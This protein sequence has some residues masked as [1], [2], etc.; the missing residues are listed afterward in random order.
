MF[1]I[2]NEKR[3]QRTSS[4]CFVPGNASAARN[5]YESPDACRNRLAPRCA[6]PEDTFCERK[7]SSPSRLRQNL[8]PFA[9]DRNSAPLTA[10]ETPPNRTKEKHRPFERR[11]TPPCSGASG[12]PPPGSGASGASPPVVKK[13]SRRQP[14]DRRLA[15][16]DATEHV[17]NC[18]QQLLR[19]GASV[20]LVE[21][22]R[23]R[24]SGDRRTLATAT[25]RPE[26]LR[27]PVAVL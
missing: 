22:R 23:Q 14:C 6:R 25:G 13:K 20:R 15:T 27:S 26:Q 16:G 4:P 24:P 10:G 19:P 2:E 3:G 1:S 5:Q 8:R 18:E 17:C 11:T 9:C 7:H 12:A 21:A